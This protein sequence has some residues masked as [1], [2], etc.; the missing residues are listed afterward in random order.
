ME[1]FKDVLETDCGTI[2]RTTFGNAD[3]NACVNKYNFSLKKTVF[4]LFRP[5]FQKWSKISR[6]FRFNTTWRVRIKFILCAGLW[7]TR[8]DALGPEIKAGRKRPAE[9]I[10]HYRHFASSPKPDTFSVLFS[11]KMNIILLFLLLLLLLLFVRGN[12]KLM[13]DRFK[14]KNVPSE[15]K[16]H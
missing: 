16:N 10:F 4:S 6:H 13:K 14:R 8:S 2:W 11:V 5:N 3:M 15:K 7:V 12:P 1:F 9:F